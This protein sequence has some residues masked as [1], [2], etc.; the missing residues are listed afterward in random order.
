MSV[1]YWLATAIF[2]STTTG[3]EVWVMLGWTD[4]SGVSVHV[5]QDRDEDSDGK[6]IK[7][8]LSPL[9]SCILKREIMHKFQTLEGETK[10]ELVPVSVSVDT[11]HDQGVDALYK[12]LYKVTVTDDL[13]VATDSEQE[14]T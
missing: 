6:M 11:L 2:K 3:A 7:V 14:V 5:C 12:V 8:D 1:N 4:E 10:T 13:Y 9:S